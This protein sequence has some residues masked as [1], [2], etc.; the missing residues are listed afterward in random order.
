MTD[1]D[2]HDDD[3]NLPGIE[4]KQVDL[5]LLRE[6]TDRLYREE[7]GFN[8]ENEDETKDLETKAPQ[9][10]ANGIVALAQR[11]RTSYDRCQRQRLLDKCNEIMQQ[12]EDAEEAQRREREAASNQPDE[13]GFIQVTSKSVGLDESKQKLEKDNKKGRRNQKRNRKKKETTGASELQD[14]Y[15]FQR[16]ETR[17]RTLQDLRKQ[18][19]EDLKKVKKMK[20]ENRFQPF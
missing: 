20:E 18:F 15:R 2:D 16:K 3:N 14:F 4:L 17:K 8:S 11:Y 12:Y 9:G 13:D 5:T 6:E 10:K 19:E 1:H 7:M